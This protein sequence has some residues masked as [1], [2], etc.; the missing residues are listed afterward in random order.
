MITIITGQRNIGKTTYVHS[1]AE[2][3][4]NVGGFVTLKKFE[5]DRFLGYDIQDV[6]TGRCVPLLLLD[7]ETEE[8][9]GAFY[10]QPSG[11]ELGLAAV[12]SAILSDD[13]ILMDEVAQME[14]GGQGFYSV[15]IEAL[16]SGKTLYITIR[17]ELIEAF[18]EAFP[19]LK[20]A[21]IVDVGL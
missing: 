14:L 18:K 12:R 11:L 5:D 19:A 16:T 6:K 8:H 4:S 10:L 21:Q 13:V 1:L 7:A 9:I 20:Q 15:L 2:S 17:S 3:L